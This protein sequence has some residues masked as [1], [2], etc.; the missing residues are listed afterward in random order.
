MKKLV[1]FISL[2]LL[3]LVGC[4]KQPSEHNYE[5]TIWTNP[6]VECCGVKDPI[7]NLEWLKDIYNTWFNQQLQYSSYEYIFLFKN[8]SNSTDFIVKK[9]KMGEQPWFGLYE[10]NGTFI[11][12]GI[13][14]EKQLTNKILKNKSEKQQTKEPAKDCDSCDEFFQTHTLIDTIAYFII[15]P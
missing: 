7:N 2:S 10:C 14:L 5:R 13:F 11:D 4:D 8:D 3:I 9:T 15:E 1:F 6:D 12:G